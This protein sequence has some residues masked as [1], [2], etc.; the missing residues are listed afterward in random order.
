MPFKSLP[1]RTSG[2]FIQK[3]KTGYYKSSWAIIS[4]NEMYV[5][6]N[7]ESSKHINLLIL[8]GAR[9]YSDTRVE[10][11]VEV[12]DNIKYSRLFEVRIKQCKLEFSLFFEKL[13]SVLEWKK[14]LVDASGDF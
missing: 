5:Y 7:K 3:T 6:Q 9:I 1:A 10:A 12:K 14:A 11:M 8:S 2:P 4:G 13:Q